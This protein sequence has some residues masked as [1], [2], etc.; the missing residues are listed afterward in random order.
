MAFY[1]QYFPHWSEFDGDR[2][3]SIFLLVYDEVYNALRKKWLLGWM[4]RKTSA[5]PFIFG[6]APPNII[7]S[8]AITNAQQSLNTLNNRRGDGTSGKIITSK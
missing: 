2:I 5:S 1:K 4:L 3:P 8:H 6:V 7:I